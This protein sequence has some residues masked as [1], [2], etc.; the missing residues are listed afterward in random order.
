MRKIEFDNQQNL[1][2]YIQYL[3]VQAME[4]ITSILETKK[5]NDNLYETKNQKI[6]EVGEKIGMKSNFI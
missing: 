1:K 5:S 3:G 4:T 2:Q 6:I